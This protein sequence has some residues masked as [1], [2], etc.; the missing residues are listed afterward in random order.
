MCFVVDSE[1]IT[2]R[3]RDTMESVRIASAGDDG[4]ADL[5]AAL[6]VINDDHL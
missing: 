2:A 6:L 1:G 3:N 4:A 5:R